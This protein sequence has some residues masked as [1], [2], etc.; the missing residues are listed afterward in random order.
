MNEHSSLPG[1]PSVTFSSTVG[2]TCDAGSF[3]KKDYLIDSSRYDSEGNWAFCRF[4]N[5]EVYAARMGFE[6]GGF[7]IMEKPAELDKT[8]L[9]LHL[10]LMTREG[11]VLWIP[12][13]TYDGDTMVSDSRK[14]DIRLDHEG[15]QIFSI[16]GWPRMNW[17]FQSQE[18][19]AE[20]N[21][22]FSIGTVTMLPDCILPHCVF[23]MWETMG[24]VS[25]YVRFK[26][27]KTEVKGMVFYDHP[28][29][30]NRQNDVVPRQLYLYTTMYFEDGSGIFGYHAEDKSGNP[31][32]YY[33]FG[34]HVDSSG[35]GSFLGDAQMQD[36]K[37]D[38]NHLP[39]SWKL[40]W[41]N[42]DYRIDVDVT[43]KPT[44]LLQSWGSSLAPQ[45]QED[46]IILPL[47][48]DSIAAV[49]T[50]DKQKALK[51]YGLAEYFNA[52]YWDV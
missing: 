31:I 39:A 1:D 50:G 47:V 22:D 7:N 34:V 13:G 21:L 8:L 30:I 42:K 36:L 29:I 45:K 10:E 38:Q 16:S 27:S 3:P 6:K 4:D 41:G 2:M 51:G 43:V 17:H 35:R 24:E 28:R 44:T 5:D 23:S 40:H 32:S 33:C 52:D 9:Q 48:L 18:G 12:T 11:A 15:R 19:D 25:G 37:L 14:L 20:A 49:K 46:F 26:D